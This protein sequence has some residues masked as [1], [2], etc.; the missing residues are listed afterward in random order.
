MPSR[1]GM[2]SARPC[3]WR[4]YSTV[5]AAGVALGAIGT[6][7][8]RPRVEGRIVARIPFENY[9]ITL[10]QQ[11]FD[12]HSI[13]DTAGKHLRMRSNEVDVAFRDG[14]D[15]RCYRS[16]AFPFFSDSIPEDYDRVDFSYT[17]SAHGKQTIEVTPD[18]A[19]REMV[20]QP[21]LRWE[22]MCEEGVNLLGKIS[23]ELLK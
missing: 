6:T 23:K 16:A 20:E 8:V 17:S 2:R 7:L 18:I 4:L 1:A 14:R 13:Q 9:T 10:T 19:L 5:F 12:P 15:I 3:R 21:Y 11:A 22:S